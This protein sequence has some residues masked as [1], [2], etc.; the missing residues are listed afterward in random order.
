[1]RQH[2]KPCKGCLWTKDSVRGWLGT[3]TPVEFL[4]TSE[5]EHRMPCH[6]M[7]DYGRDDWERLAAKAPQCVG[8][9][10]HFGNRCK[11]PRNL[12]LITAAADREAVFSRHQD[13]I[14]HHT[15]TGTPPRIVI[16][17]AAVLATSSEEEPERHSV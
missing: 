15:P 1:M 6:N 12:E 4:Q 2:K 11:V 9:A 3:A 16:I 14:D 17:S 5:A 7:V 8:R 13:F 10:V